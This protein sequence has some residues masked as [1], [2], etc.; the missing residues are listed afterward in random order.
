L[1]NLLQKGHK[2]IDSNYFWHIYQGKSNKLLKG[3]PVALT[4][5]VDPLYKGE[6]ES[7]D[8]SRSLHSFS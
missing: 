8:G 5:F 2:E 3:L 6:I 1:R 7:K 4:A